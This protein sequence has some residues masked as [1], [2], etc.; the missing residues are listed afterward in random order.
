MV[1]EAATD[2]ELMKQSR[3][4]KESPQQLG[5]GSCVGSCFG[6]ITRRFQAIQLWRTLQ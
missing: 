4:Q 3:D 1:N 2:E 5:V 6:K